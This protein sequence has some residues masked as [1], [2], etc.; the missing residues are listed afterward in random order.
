M[1]W[2]WEAGA[3]ELTMEGGNLFVPIAVK[4]ATPRNEFEEFGDDEFFCSWTYFW[5]GFWVQ[6]NSLFGVWVGFG[7]IFL[8]YFNSLEST[9][10]PTQTQI[11]FLVM[12]LLMMT[13]TNFKMM[14]LMLMMMMKLVMKYVIRLTCIRKIHDDHI[15]DTEVVLAV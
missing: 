9:P 13:M 3:M 5:R 2:D 14:N 15:I 12:C 6:Q 8:G 7:F 11:F 4:W 10:Y 1:Y